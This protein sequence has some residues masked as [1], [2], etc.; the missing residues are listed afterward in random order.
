MNRS[1]LPPS[2][3][4]FDWMMGCFSVLIMIGVFQDG[5]AH[6]HG[7]VDQSF[8]TPWHAILYSTM[9][10]SGIA[11]LVTGVGN[12]RRGYSLRSGLPYGYWTGA[13]GVVLF[14]FGG[15][16]DMYWHTVFG[17]EQDIVGLISPS[18]LTLAL[19]GAL[20]FAGV[21][22]SVGSQ[23][24]SQTTG[25][26]R[27]GPAVL[28]ALAT[29]MLLGFFTQY[30]QPFADDTMLSILGRE[31]ISGGAIY[32]VS[33][34]GASET[35]V[36]VRPGQD[37]YGA[38]LS[39][40]GKYL[41]YR[42]GN[43]SGGR[44]QP[45]DIYV[46]RTDGSNAVR[47]THSGRHDTQPAWAPDGTRIAF[48]S[49]PAGTS[50]HFKLETVRPDGSQ[51]STLVDGVTTISSPAWSPD[52]HFIAFASR[53]GLNAQIA[54]I[55]A[56]G[57]AARWLPGTA[58]GS[59]PAWSKDG[60]LAFDTDQGNIAS[61]APGAKTAHD[62]VQNASFPAWSTDGKRLAYLASANGGTDVFVADSLGTGA[63]NVSQLSGLDASQA[64][65][66]SNGRLF[67]TAAGRARATQTGIGKAYGMDSTMIASL[68]LMGVLLLFL[69]RWRAPLGTMTVL[70]GGG[71][72]ALSTQSD[73]YFAVPAAIAVGIVAD[74]AIAML[75]DRVRRGFA[76]YAFAFATPSVLFAL[77]FAAA[78]AHLH[79]LGWPANML[80]G[81]PIIAGFAGLLVA[82]CY[83][84]PI[85][86]REQVAGAREDLEFGSAPSIATTF[87][88][89]TASARSG[90]QTY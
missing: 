87:A 80:L 55:P 77:Y 72:L 3:P 54:M 76:F 37:L 10:I 19:G 39:P 49:I 62:L 17:I 45:S 66:S 20:V 71:Y 84:P 75:R 35:R 44:V 85:A 13:A 21:L 61:I 90:G 43:A 34:G 67:F 42:A 79:E 48:I 14:I 18:H 86:L 73:M 16:F 53:N 40:D 23:Y 65:W 32:S 9:A 28:A 52:S 57:G 2:S 59:Q 70:L 26:R 11:L 8:F 27:V 31:E 41:A 89:E 22:R 60:I 33:P 36:A 38:A 24:D 63:M 78:A 12:L 83:A 69:R 81:T 46:A 64:A 7:L 15:A 82:F 29:L 1:A 50:G 58:G 4:A 88:P 56:R 74:I 25:W 5:W 68:T 6:N 30:A 51:L 47:I